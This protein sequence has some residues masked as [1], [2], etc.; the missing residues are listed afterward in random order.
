MADAVQGTETCVAEAHQEMCVDADITVAPSVHAGPVKVACVGRPKLDQCEVED[1]EDPD[2]QREDAGGERGCHPMRN[3]RF[4]VR[5]TICVTI[6]LIFE[7]TAEAALSTITCETPQPGPC[8]PS[9][10]RPKT[11]PEV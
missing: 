6:P 5:Q 9:Q 4:S 1:E 2:G 8:P 7:A 3:C 10:R 11:W